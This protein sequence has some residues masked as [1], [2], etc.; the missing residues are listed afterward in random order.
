MSIR[1]VGS[2]TY[3]GGAAGVYV[4]EVNP[5][6]GST[7]ESATSGHFSADV[8][9]MVYFGGPDVAETKQNTVTGSI[10]KFE[11]SGDEENAWAVNL[12]GIVGNREPKRRLRK[13][14]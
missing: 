13:Y 1:F 10:T 5:S 14:Q 6:G 3:K 11:L 7:P 4:H 2:A 12:S 8:S 9:L